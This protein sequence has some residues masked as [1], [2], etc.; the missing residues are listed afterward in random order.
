MDQRAIDTI[1]ERRVHRP[2]RHSVYQIEG[3]DGHLRKVTQ[4]HLRCNQTGRFSKT[5][6]AAGTI[7]RMDQERSRAVGSGQWAVQYI[8]ASRRHSKS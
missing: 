8:C 5:G 3:C 1:I 6:K 2:R 7:G 4:K